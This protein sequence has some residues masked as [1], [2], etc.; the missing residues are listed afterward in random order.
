M[1]LTTR[2]QF[3]HFRKLNSY[4]MYEFLT[5]E[6]LKVSLMTFEEV[7]YNNKAKKFCQRTHQTM[8]VTVEKLL[9]PLQGNVK[10]E[11]SKLKNDSIFDNNDRD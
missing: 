6:G 11:K 10:Q 3:A 1:Y 7:A 5:V 4:M 9:S 8:T 2:K